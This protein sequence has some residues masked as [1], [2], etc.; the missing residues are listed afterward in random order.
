M[1]KKKRSYIP[2]RSAVADDGVVLDDGP[3]GGLDLVES[4]SHEE[5][6]YAGVSFKTVQ[7]LQDGSA[8]S[9]AVADP[10]DHDSPKDAA[11]RNAPVDVG[12][13]N[14]GT[15]GVDNAIDADGVSAPMIDR[16]ADLP[17]TSDL[18]GSLV[19]TV[20]DT[21]DT[22]DTVD[23]VDMVDTEEPVNPDDPY[24]EMQADGVASS[25]RK[26]AEIPV[27]ED[28]LDDINDVLA[29]VV[30]P[31]VD[32]VPRCGITFA[33]EEYDHVKGRSRPVSSVSVSGAE[34]SVTRSRMFIRLDITFGNSSDADLKRFWGMIEL[35]FRRLG[36]E[37]EESHLHTL[38]SLVLV[39][40][41]LEGRYIVTM[42]DPFFYCIQGTKPG[43]TARR[44]SL[45]FLPD[46]VDCLIG[47]RI[48][49]RNL[50]ASVLRDEQQIKETALYYEERQRQL[51]AEREA[52]RDRAVDPGKAVLDKARVPVAE[53][54]WKHV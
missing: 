45:L 54:R 47:E 2:E 23:T 39:P 49:R 4:I 43:D 18:S 37:V 8:L 19:D 17:G 14:D 36:E 28:E 1:K 3:A 13:D 44:I 15:A 24:R 20:P 40:L 26:V 31:V 12:T 35:G 11:G 34:V 42:D 46:D 41:D 48:D 25:S 29:H 51:D 52:S 7:D 21:G 9:D 33:I 27:C 10:V 53:R 38:M 32:G 5:D 16:Q 6:P 30:G 22:V 50:E